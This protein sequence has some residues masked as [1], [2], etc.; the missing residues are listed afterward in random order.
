MVTKPKISSL[1]RS[2]LCIPQKSPLTLLECVICV[3]RLVLVWCWCLWVLA[4][5]RSACASPFHPIAK[6]T[7]FSGK[8]SL[9]ILMIFKH[10]YN[11]IEHLY[12]QFAQSSW[13]SYEKALGSR[14]RL[15][16]W[17]I[18]TLST[19]LLPPSCATLSP[20]STWLCFDS[21]LDTAYSNVSTIHH[22]C[23]VT[24]QHC[25]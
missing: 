17:V 22:L 25:L 1:L 16:W 12:A 10:I 18:Q 21:K 4:C 11:G 9:W 2:I 3:L 24:D 20:Y 5:S 7:L 23:I 15:F 14:K 6:I 13:F 19:L 8:H